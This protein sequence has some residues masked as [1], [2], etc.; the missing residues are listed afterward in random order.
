[1]FGLSSTCRARLQRNFGLG[2]RDATGRGS[3]GG[4][5]DWSHV[6]GFQASELLV[7]GCCP[8]AFLL[9]AR[10]VHTEPNSE[11]DVDSEHSLLLL[12]TLLQLICLLIMHLL[13]CPRI[14]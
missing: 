4:E 13:A 9:A 12:A 6:D 7:D 8:V 1:M 3:S 2:S 11:N 5:V 14:I 10:V